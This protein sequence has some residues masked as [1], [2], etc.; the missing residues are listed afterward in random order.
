[1]AMD[2]VEQSELLDACEFGDLQRVCHMIASGANP[3]RVDPESGWTP[4]HW[5][6]R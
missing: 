6:A 3:N 1:M 5:A 2:R 4:L